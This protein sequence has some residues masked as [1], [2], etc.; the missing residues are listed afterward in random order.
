MHVYSWVHGRICNNPK[1]KNAYKAVNNCSIEYQ[2]T[3][4]I[5]ST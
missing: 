2:D 5:F 1:E 4:I 3:S